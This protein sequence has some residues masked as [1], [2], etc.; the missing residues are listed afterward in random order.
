MSKLFLSFTGICL[1]VPRFRLDD[2]Q[3]QGRNEVRVLLAESRNPPPVP[4]GPHDHERHLP[5][6]VCLRGDVIHGPGRRSEDDWFKFNGREWAVFFLNDQDLFLGSPRQS[7]QIDT[8][9]T[10]AGTGC[11]T[12]A[13]SFLWAGPLERISPGS[14]QV[15]D[16]CF[17]RLRPDNAVIARVALTQGRLHTF[18]I[19]SES[20]RAILF[21]FKVP[22]AGNPERHQQALADSVLCEVDFEGSFIELTTKLFRSTSD[23]TVSRLYPAGVDSPQLKISLRARGG[24]VHAFVKNMPGPDIDGSRPRMPRRDPDV[25]FAHVYLLS[26]SSSKANVPHYLRLCE[27]EVELCVGSLDLVDKDKDFL[28]LHRGNP[29]CPPPT[30]M[31]HTEESDW[32]FG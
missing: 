31:A 14:Q 13:C 29:N 28:I 20:G 1:F 6:L 17:R 9:G 7:L 24:R 21:E 5:R 19:A 3:H 32:T 18:E 23:T 27:G 12:S 25:H 26:K 16:E 2:P 11:P 15:K 22:G 4:H 8:G 10:G 30:A